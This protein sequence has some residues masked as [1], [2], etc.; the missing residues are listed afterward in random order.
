MK[1]V[2]LIV[3]SRVPH[4]CQIITGFLMLKKQ[5]YEV[6]IVDGGNDGSLLSNMPAIRAE[7]R[8]QRLLYD[9]GDGYNVPEAVAAGLDASDFYFKRS[10]SQKKNQEIGFRNPEKM[11]PLG[12][13][14]HVT[15]W[16]NPV[17]EPLWKTLAKPFFG[18]TPDCWFR[19]GVFE[20]KALEKNGE[21]VKILFL[22]RLWNDHEPGFSDEENAERTYINNMR[23]DIIRA[24]RETYGD[25]FVGG[26]NDN[27][28]SRAWAPD[29]IM[30]AK[31]T[32]RRK[33]LQLLH[34]SDI[35]IGSMGL[36]ESIGWKTG[37]YVAAAKAIVN[38][39]MHFTVT[40]D[41]EEGRNYLAFQTKDE[42]L[43]AV[44]C[45]V[46]DPARLYA[47]KLANEQYYQDYLRPDMLVKHSLEVVDRALENK[48]S[49][50]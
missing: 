18:R 6:E 34:S 39:R 46:E 33:Y 23:I 12:F 22:A 8:G 41:F 1:K 9:V 31:Y 36:F 38:E 42:C 10:F 29:L 17:G 49:K 48:F 19:P 11:Y 27:A 16:G 30:P 44:R 13:N 5:G 40:G 14:Y 50:N 25:A 15:C 2:K 20:G 21:P 45:L 37:E 3:G 47:M 32:E 35:C 26:L 7:Y 28:L 4:V 43:E 24:L